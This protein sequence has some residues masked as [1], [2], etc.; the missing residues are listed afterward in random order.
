MAGED[1]AV[2]SP[3]MEDKLRIEMLA[4]TY[5]M[6]KTNFKEG[7]G[8]VYMTHPT[9]AIYRFL[10]S[11]FV[12]ISNAGSDRML[13]DEA[14]MLASW[15]QIEAVDYHQEVIIGGALRFTPYHAGHVLGACMF[16]LEIAGIRVLYTGDYS[17]EEDRHLVQAEVPPVRPDVLICESTYGTQSLEPRLD[18]EMR[19]TSLIHTIINRGGRV[20]LPV[21][22]LGRAQELLLLLDEYW[23]AHPELHSIPIYYASSLARKCISIYQ[24]YIHTMN[25]HIRARFNRRDNPF[26]FKHVSNLRSLDKFE[27]KGPCVMMASPGFMQNGISREL[28]ERWAPDKRNG[29]IVNGYSVEGTMARDILSDPEEIMGLSGQRIPRRMS[30]DYISFSAHV[31]YTQNSRFID[32]VK[33]KHI[34][35]VHGEVKNMSGL[36]AALQSRYNDRDDDVKIYMPRNCDPLFLAFRADRTAKVIGHLA[37]KPPLTDKPIDGLLV[38]KDFSYTVLAPQDL[39]EFTGLGT[40]TILQRQR[41]AL[42]VGWELVRWHLEG[43]YGSIQDG[44]DL[45]GVRTLRIMNVVDIKQ[46]HAHELLLE[47][48]ASISND[49]VADS[50]IALLLSI[51]SSP[52]A[53]KVTMQNHVCAHQHEPDVHLTQQEAL[54]A[55]LEAHFGHVQMAEVGGHAQEEAAM[56]SGETQIQGADAPPDE[57]PADAPVTDNEPTTPP[58][59]QLLATIPGPLRAAMTI[60][61]D[62]EPAMIELTNMH[63]YALSESLRQ[64]VERL[65]AMVRSTYQSLSDAFYLVPTNTTMLFQGPHSQVQPP[66]EST[67]PRKALEACP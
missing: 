33:A 52:A 24:T 46:P 60:E 22:V 40:N 58:L 15:R 3:M 2:A 39:G 26:V 30:V 48:V 64:R 63:V 29:V 6:E 53:V 45:E 25:H 10:M 34:V 36:R 18:K 27:D 56:E 7:R 44:V 62:G 5:I 14:E 21:F 8:K 61:L 17:R 66:T 4:L 12:R 65:V 49:M 19:F 67:A 1:A 55:L 11:D 59:A 9:K 41:V 47:W 57:I 43:M 32:E 42:R 54:T 20:L 28:L 51:D 31:D 37:D 13:F 35:L 50:A 23:E 38:A 16:M